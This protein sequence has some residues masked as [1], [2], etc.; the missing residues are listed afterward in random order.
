MSGRYTGPERRTA[1]ESWHLDKKFSIGII[2]IVLGQCCSFI[3]YGAKIDSKVQDTALRV[4]QLEAWKLK[5]DDQLAKLNATQSAAGQKLDDLVQTV[6]HT[7][8]IVEKYLY[9]K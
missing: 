1:P 7:D 4:Q 3:W 8:D 6:H 2:V 5:Q 9:R